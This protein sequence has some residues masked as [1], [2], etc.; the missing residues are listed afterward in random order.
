MC[1]GKP[2][3]LTTEDTEGTEEHQAATMD[4]VQLRPFGLV[5]FLIQKLRPR[6]LGNFPQFP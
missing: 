5:I 6:L 1:G 4:K 2:D 3:H